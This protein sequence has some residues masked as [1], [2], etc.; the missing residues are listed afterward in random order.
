MPAGCSLCVHKDAEQIN[1]EMVLHAATA[2][3][4]SKKYKVSMSTVTRHRAH[5]TQRL[6][7]AQE[8]REHNAAD[9]L[10]ADT[11]MLWRESLVALEKS[12]KAVKTHAITEGSGKN[13][14]TVFKEYQDI[15]AVMSAIKVCHENRR[16][17][18]DATDVFGQKGVGGKVGVFLTIGLPRNETPSSEPPITVQASLVQE[19]PPPEPKPKQVTAPESPADLSPEEQ[20]RRIKYRAQMDKLKAFNKSKKSIKATIKAKVWGENHPQAQK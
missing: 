10:L 11:E 19:P 6:A 9:R 20:E 5:I 13:A 15:G 8:R 16:L 12:K 17:Y 2:A 7:L 4:I 14:R 18:G 1:R 3:S